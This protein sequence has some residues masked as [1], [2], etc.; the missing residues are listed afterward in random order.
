MTHGPHGDL[1][2]AFLAEVRRATPDDWRDFAR[3]A[4]PTQAS[5]DATRAVTGLRLS[6][7]TLSSV[8]SAALK[9]Y[10]AV[11]P[12]LDDTAGPGRRRSSIAGRIR[13][14]SSAVSGHDQLDP[15]HLAVLLRPF[16]E[17]GCATAAQVLRGAGPDPED[18]VAAAE[19][20]PAG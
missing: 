3:A 17:I 5:V 1:V 2:D 8:D 18:S 12:S 20:E 15:T 10:R 14:A 6:A 11:L 9:T 16:A 4:T 19:D 13:S 7:A